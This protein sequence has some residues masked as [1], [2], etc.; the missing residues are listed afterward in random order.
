MKRKITEYLVEKLIERETIPQNEKDLY[1]YGLSEGI[2]IIQNILYTL[3]IGIIFGNIIET[4]TFLCFYILLRS[5]AG[6][7]HAETEKNCFWYSI[8]L[9]IVVEIIFTAM[10]YGQWNF[11]KLIV[12]TI[13]SAIILCFSPLDNIN[14]PISESEKRNFKKIVYKV[15]LIGIIILLLSCVLAIEEIESGIIMGIIIEALLLVIGKFKQ[16]R[17]SFYINVSSH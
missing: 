11:F 9:V 12:L 10:H 1:Q 4:I 17:K 7:Y 5:F 14:K 6:G 8:L 3:L 13:A 15:L 2:T 16:K